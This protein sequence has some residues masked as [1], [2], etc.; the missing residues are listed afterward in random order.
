LGG[1]KVKSVTVG[2]IDGIAA[3]KTEVSGAGESVLPGGLRQ[4]RGGLQTVEVISAI[5]AIFR[6]PQVIHSAILPV[7]WMTP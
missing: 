2:A 7:V 3:P 4:G 1:G 5:N 6:C